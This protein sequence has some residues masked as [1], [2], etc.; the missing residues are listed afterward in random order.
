[1]HNNLNQFLQ[2]LIDYLHILFDLLFA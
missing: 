1:M 2:I